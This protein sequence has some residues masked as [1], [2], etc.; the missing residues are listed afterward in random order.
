MPAG[1]LGPRDGLPRASR[2][3]TTWRVEQKDL[4]ASHGVT[5]QR[6]VTAFSRRFV[7]VL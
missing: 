2:L 6:M 4:G 1:F 7:E 3:G 5:C